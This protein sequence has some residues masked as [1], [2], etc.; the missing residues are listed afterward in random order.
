[1]STVQINYKSG[2]SVTMTADEFSVTK[3]STGAA[4]IEWKLGDKPTMRP[5]FMNLGEIESVWEVLK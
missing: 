4:H 3:D 1:M 5:L 2:Q